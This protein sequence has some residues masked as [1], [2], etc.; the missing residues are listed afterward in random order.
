YNKNKYLP[1]IVFYHGGAFYMGSV[2]THHPITR[3]LALMTGFIVISVEYRLSPEHPFPA[4]L[5]DC[6]KVTQ[7][8]LNSN[9]AEKLNID[10][11][12]VAIS[13]DSAGGNL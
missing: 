4:G 3:R 2:E 12:R 5:D 10:S 11:K 1:A 13:G 8:I 9:N 6:M 7:Y